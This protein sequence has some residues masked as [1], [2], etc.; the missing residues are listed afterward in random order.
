MLRKLEVNTLHFVQDGQHDGASSN[1]L[2]K[3]VQIR[4]RKNAYN[5]VRAD[6]FVR[7]IGAKNTGKRQGDFSSLFPVVFGTVIIHQVINLA[8]HWSSLVYVYMYSMKHP[9]ENALGSMLILRHRLKINTKFSISRASRRRHKAGRRQWR[10]QLR[11]GGPGK[12]AAPG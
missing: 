11:R 12:A 8:I 10:D 6:A 5:F 9:G 2:S 4:L 3:D 1:V 7:S